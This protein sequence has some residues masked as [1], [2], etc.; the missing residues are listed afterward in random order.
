[1]PFACLQKCAEV[2]DPL[3]VLLQLRLVPQPERELPSLRVF[4]NEPTV[5]RL[6]GD[7][8]RL[9]DGLVGC[10]ADCEQTKEK[11]RVASSRFVRFAR[12]HDFMEQLP[13]HPC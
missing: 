7:G 10:K 1:M 13:C 4:G 6:C 8:T 3:N 11:H 12:T 5:R 2:H 9:S